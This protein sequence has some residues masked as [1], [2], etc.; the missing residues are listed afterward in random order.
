[1][2]CDEK[3]APFIKTGLPSFLGLLLVVS[4][5]NGATS[6]AA[7]P[8]AH[9]ASPNGKYE[10][11]FN[12]SER[13]YSVSDRQCSMATYSIIE[14][15]KQSILWVGQTE[16]DGQIN[17]PTIIWSP[18]SLG[19]LLI[20]RPQR[21]DVSLVYLKVEPTITLK[22]LDIY[23]FIKKSLS[24]TQF[25]VPAQALPKIWFLSDWKWQN[26]QEATGTLVFAK[27]KYFLLKIKFLVDKE[28]LE[29]V[30]ISTSDAFQN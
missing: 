8:V 10:I 27:E 9:F 7:M 12:I 2:I 16:Y 11:Y 14:K 30:D 3:Q 19:V 1:M 4:F 17:S 26:K 5:L 6:F 28:D 23:K 18:S 21:G 13:I 22:K 24:K 25:E 29:L 20:E 15:S